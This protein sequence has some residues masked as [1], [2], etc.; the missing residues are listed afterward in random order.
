VARATRSLGVV[1]V[2]AESVA[3]S[4]DHDDLGVVSESVEDCGGDRGV[5]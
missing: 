5:V 4:Y 2:A 3:P 1:E